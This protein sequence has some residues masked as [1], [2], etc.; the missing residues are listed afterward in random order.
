MSAAVLADVAARIGR[1]LSSDEETQVPTLLEDAELLIKARHS[2]VGELDQAML[3]LVECRAVLR[4]LKNPDGRRQTSIDDHS[5]TTDTALSSGELYISEDEWD[6]IA[7]A[8]TTKSDAFTIRPFYE[9]D[10]YT[11]ESW[12]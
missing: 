3:V 10:P 11:Q 4:V 1:P 6:M 5:W 7:P 9:P 2:D 8:D 12:A